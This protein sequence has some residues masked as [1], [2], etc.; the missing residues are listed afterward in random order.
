MQIPLKVTTEYTLLSSL[1]KLDDLVST[2][3]EN[4][5]TSCAIC[6]VN[7]EGSNLFYKKLK[8]NNIKPI[9]GLNVKIDN[10]NI[11]LYAKNYSGYKDLLAI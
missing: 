3:K 5:V 7:L 2:L 11:Y 1:I 8:S 9:I 4:N 10:F 6:D